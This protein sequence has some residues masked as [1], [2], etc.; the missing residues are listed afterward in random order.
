MKHGKKYMETAKAVDR[1]KLYDPDEAIA[2][3][4]K[5]AV[6]KFDETYSQVGRFIEEVFGKIYFSVFRLRNIVQIHS[7]YL[8]HL[9]GTFAVTS[10]DQWCMHIDKSSLLEE[11]VNGI[12][13][14]RT[15][16]EY[17]LKRIGSRTQV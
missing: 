13:N 7:C 10:C 17:R 11:L 6:A 1:A 4:K 3:A 2:L 14:Q 15:H 16:T 12:G 5:S 8:E 9:S